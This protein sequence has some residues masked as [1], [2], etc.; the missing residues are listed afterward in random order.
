MVAKALGDGCPQQGHRDHVISIPVQGAE[1]GTGLGGA[2]PPAAAFPRP[3]VLVFPPLPL[4]PHLSPVGTPPAALSTAEMGAGVGTEHDMG[5]TPWR[6]KHRH[7]A[8]Y[9]RAPVK[10]LNVTFETRV[11]EHVIGPL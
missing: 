2:S 10:K 7:D 4:L 6:A 1:V 8:G 9:F 3:S 5:W 11:A